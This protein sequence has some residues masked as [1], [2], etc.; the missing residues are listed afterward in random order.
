[1]DLVLLRRLKGFGLFFLLVPEFVPA[2]TA[3]DSVVPANCASD[4]EDPPTG[5]LA[6]DLSPEAPVGEV[7][8]QFIAS[9]EE[10]RNKK[11]L[12]ILIGFLS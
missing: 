12:T 7:E 2:P 10:R 9:D 5:L 3:G 6:T 1:M 8:C 11:G 4:F